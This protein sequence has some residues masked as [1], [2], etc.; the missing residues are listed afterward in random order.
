MEMCSNLGHYVNEPDSNEL[1]TIKYSVVG[2]DFSPSPRNI[3]K[4]LEQ[5]NPIIYV[6]VIF[7]FFLLCMN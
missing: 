6:A 4:Q 2:F 5:V 1:L 7:L 3:E